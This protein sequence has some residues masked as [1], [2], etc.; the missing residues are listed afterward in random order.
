MEAVSVMGFLDLTSK[1][2]TSKACIL[3]RIKPVTS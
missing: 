1:L 2:P 3:G